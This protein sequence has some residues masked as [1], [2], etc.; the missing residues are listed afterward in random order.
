MIAL[1]DVTL[2]WPDGPTFRFDVAVPAGESVGVIG[3][4]GSGKSTLLHLVAGFLPPATGRVVLDGEDHTG[5]PPAARPVSMMFQAG[6]LFDHLDVATNVGLGLSPRF[7]RRSVAMERVRE[8]LAAVG[9][10]GFE[11]RRAHGLSGGEQQRVALARAMVRDR[12]I[13]LLDEPFAAL[14][15]SMRAAFVDLIARMQ[16][17][18]GLTLLLVSHAPSELAG[19]CGRLLFIEGG[20]IAQDGPFADL[21]DAPGDTPLGR[22]LGQGG[23]PAV[24]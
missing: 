1:E 20:R 23:R 19:L 18:R 10:A 24:R 3:P 16:A 9:L 8:A 15:P 6:N 5:S 12:P 13:L 4:S 7:S 22:Y 2:G 14:G 21:M 17:E 11:D